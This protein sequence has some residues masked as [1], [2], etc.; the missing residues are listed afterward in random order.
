M[1]KERLVSGC[2]ECGKR[3]DEDGLL[4]IQSD[5]VVLCYDC[6]VHLKKHC[7]RPLWRNRQ[8]KGDAER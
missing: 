8:N 1:K 7:V 2:E 5:F 4:L 3:F 6:Y